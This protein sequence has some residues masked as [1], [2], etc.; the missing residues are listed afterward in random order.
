MALLM[1]RKVL[2]PESQNQVKIKYDELCDLRERCFGGSAFEFDERT[3]LSNTPKSGSGFSS[4]FGKKE[5]LGSGLLAI[6]TTFSIARQ[7]MRCI[8]SGAK[9]NLHAVGP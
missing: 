3:T 1:R 4:P 5:A 2:T 9:S 7:M 6:R 8:N